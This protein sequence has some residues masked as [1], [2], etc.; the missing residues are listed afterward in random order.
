MGVA[1]SGHEGARR[2]VCVSLPDPDCDGEPVVALVE[3]HTKPASRTNIGRHEIEPRLA[4]HVQ[5]LGARRRVDPQG[6]AAVAVMVDRQQRK[7]LAA[8]LVVGHA[9]SGA[10]LDFGQRQTD[11]PYRR[12]DVLRHI[13]PSPQR[14]N[15]PRALCPGVSEQ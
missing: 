11:F 3:M 8:D 2:D 14:D 10:L 6:D 13:Q 15:I 12:L 7:R 4:V 1:E 5:V 9:V